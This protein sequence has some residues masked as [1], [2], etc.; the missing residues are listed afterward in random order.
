MLIKTDGF[1]AISCDHCKK[2]LPFAN[3][4][5]MDLKACPSCGKESFFIFFPAL[6]RPPGEIKTGTTLEDETAAS[7]YYHP[8]KKAEIV[9]D[10]CGRFLCALCDVLFNNQHLCSACIED[11]GKKGR[12]KSLENKR[13]L[14]DETALAVALIPIIFFPLTFVTAPIAL[15]IGIRYWKEP[16]SIIPR[17]KL[18]MLLAIVLALFQMSGWAINFYFHFT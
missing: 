14:W 16:S 18:R 5:K 17:S 15:Y 8:Q 13:L 1:P 11:G 12:L 6:I 7:C 2:P 9:C 3:L 10:F 4:S